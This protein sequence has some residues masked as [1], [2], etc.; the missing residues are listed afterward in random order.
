MAIEFR[1]ASANSS[2]SATQ[3]TLSKP[4]GTVEGDVMIVSLGIHHTGSERPV[5]APTGW[6]LLQVDESYVQYNLYYKVAGASEPSS[7]TF[8]W[9]DATVGEPIGSIVS[10]SG[11]D[12]SDP[13]SDSS[14]TANLGWNKSLTGLSVNV[15]NPNS[16]VI[17]IA[18][19]FNVNTT[20]ATPSGY[21]SKFTWTHAYDV[22][23]QSTSI[24]IVEKE[25]SSTG[26]SGDVSLTMNL[27]S[28][29]ENAAGVALNPAPTAN[30]SAFFQL[31]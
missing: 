17:F 15:S 25:F 16:M 1:A 6:T 8:S 31:F 26:E 28:D 24:K 27:N 20:F 13:I 22:T 19:N 14:T 21:T 7:Y 9:S 11:V 2:R 5:T 18:S 23:Y 10:Y 4:T 12:T 29:T 3:L 30:T